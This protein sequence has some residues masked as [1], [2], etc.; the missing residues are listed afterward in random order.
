[1]VAK[2]NKIRFA[3]ATKGDRVQMKFFDNAIAH[4]IL[5]LPQTTRTVL[6]THLER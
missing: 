3:Q 6:D 2:Q 4:A 1:M 5:R